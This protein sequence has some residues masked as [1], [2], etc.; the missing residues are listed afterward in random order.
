M[1]VLRAGLSLSLP[2]P[3]FSSS[4]SDHT[5]SSIYKSHPSSPHSGEA[6]FPATPSQIPS[7]PLS[8]HVPTNSLT[9]LIPQTFPARNN[10]RSVLISPSPAY[11]YPSRDR[12]FREDFIMLTFTVPNR[13]SRCRTSALFLPRVLLRP[14]VGSVRCWVVES[15][16]T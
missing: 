9:F 4:S 13:R 3:S 14:K 12:S 15:K 7:L 2:S 6:S 10:G 1:G 16:L 8:N 5:L 11:R